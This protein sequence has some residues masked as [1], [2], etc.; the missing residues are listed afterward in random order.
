MA[1][2]QTLVSLMTQTSLHAG[3]G[4]DIVSVIDLPI[5][6]EAHTDWPCVYGSAVKGALRAKFE[7]EAKDNIVNQ[8]FGQETDSRLQAGCLAITDARLL[9]LPVRSLTSHF[10]WITCPEVLR[11]WRCDC[12]RLGVTLALPDRQLDVSGMNALCHSPQNLYLEEYRFTVEQTDLS[13]WC[14]ALARMVGDDRH[15]DLH[16]QLVIVSNNMFTY[17]AKHATPVVAHNKLNDA[18][19]TDSLWYEESLPPDTL[20]Y[21]MVN[22][23]ISR[24]DEQKPASENLSAFTETLQTNPWLQMGGNETVG[25]GFCHVICL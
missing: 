11:R 16:E 25:M 3:V 18:K 20:L 24:D 5:Q 8:L 2:T 6:R 7:T 13:D 22:A 4:Q 21:T 12:S 19:T 9:L 15:K 14:N 23:F 17:L 1:T 10:K